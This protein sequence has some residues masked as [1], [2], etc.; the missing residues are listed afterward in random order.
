MTADQVR[1]VGALGAD[2]G[3]IVVAKDS[4]HQDLRSLVDAVKA[5]PTSIAFAGGSAA[6]GFDHLKVLQARCSRPTAEDIRPVRCVSF[7]GGGDAITQ[8]LGGHV[9]VDD[10]RH[11]RGC[12]LHPVRR[13][14]GGGR[15]LGGA[16]ARPVR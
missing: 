6:G 16:A 13:R 14:A 3:V 10:R 1:F 11:L 8:M 7:D 9:R 12:R 15:A 4:P 2:Y 5:D